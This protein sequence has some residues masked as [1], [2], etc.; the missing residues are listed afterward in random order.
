MKI[1]SW[2]DAFQPAKGAPPQALGAFMGWCLTGTWSVLWLAAFLSAAAV[3]LRRE[4]H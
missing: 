2:I 1:E 4:Q 3:P